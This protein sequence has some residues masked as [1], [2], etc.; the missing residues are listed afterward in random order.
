MN[1]VFVVMNI[2][3]MNIVVIV[4]HDSRTIIKT[5]QQGFKPGK[6]RRRERCNASHPDRTFSN[7]YSEDHPGLKSFVVR[8]RFVLGLPSI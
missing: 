6:G 7:A 2:V 4:A 5:S 1:I 8:C 3:V